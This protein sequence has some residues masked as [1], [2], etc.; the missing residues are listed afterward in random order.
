M[1]SSRSLRSRV[2]EIPSPLSYS[3][4]ES[5]TFMVIFVVDF[6]LQ[7]MTAVYVIRFRKP[8]IY[9]F[10]QSCSSW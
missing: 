1:T 4:S 5:V 6:S 9:I 7:C 2:A 8:T 10:D 3:V